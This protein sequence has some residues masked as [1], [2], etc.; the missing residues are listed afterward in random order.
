MENGGGW[1]ISRT[2]QRPGK[3]GG[4]IESMGAILAE[5]PSSRGYGS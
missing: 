4:P 1:A 3:G 5:T 2:S